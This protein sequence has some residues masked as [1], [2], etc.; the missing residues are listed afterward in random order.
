MVMAS[1]K[2]KSFPRFPELDGMRGIA[3]LL[4]FFHHVT[5]MD[6]AAPLSHLQSVLKHVFTAGRA[7]VDL[8]FVLSGFLI[9][10]ILLRERKSA[11]YYRDFYWKRG[12]RVLPLYLV[13]L[14]LILALIPHSLR[15]VVLALFFLANFAS[16][17]HVYL[18]TPFWSLA[19]EEQFYLLWPAVVRRRSGKVVGRVAVGVAVLCFLL[20][21]A[22][23]RGGH[24]NY[25]LTFLHCD[26]LAL[27]ALLACLFLQSQESDRPFSG[28]APRLWL[29]LLVG[30]LA[31]ISAP[32]ISSSSWL[33]SNQANLELTA[34]TL[35]SVGVIGLC[36]AYTNSRWLGWFRSP[37][38]RFFGV[39]SYA[40]YVIHLFVLQAY[41]RFSPVPFVGNNPAYL[42]RMVVVFAI[43]VGLSLASR[44]GIELP[45]LSL[46][47]L[48]LAHTAPAAETQLPILG[49]H[50]RADLKPVIAD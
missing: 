12:L 20:R 17:L 14:L 32:F 8:F 15:Y 22:F 35:V 27:G 7:G 30:L 45:A 36:L 33:A 21:V 38:L 24:T 13:V 6:D 10:S 28:F 39:I 25:Y 42:V 5:L 19:V 49:E 50:A 26:G 16:V 40:F 44:Y 29:V 11:T 41:D 18:T 4:V 48:V 47:R 1:A 37:V 2:L 31:G 43:A 3:V 34:S 46:R 23:A 9:T